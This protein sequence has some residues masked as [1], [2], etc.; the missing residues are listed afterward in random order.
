[1]TVRWLAHMWTHAHTHTHTHT[2]TQSI[3]TRTHTHTHTC[4]SLLSLVQS[5]VVFV[6]E[7]WV[8]PV[9]LVLTDQTDHHARTNLLHHTTSPHLLLQVKRPR[10]TNS[11]R[12]CVLSC[13]VNQAMEVERRG[14]VVV[15]H[16]RMGHQ[17]NRLTREA[18]QQLMQALDKAES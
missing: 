2:H 7:L 4:A 17:Q 13:S 5:S 12:A 1:M 10:R 8:D 15:I 3:H 6:K 18:M 16:M 14:G 11:R 9:L